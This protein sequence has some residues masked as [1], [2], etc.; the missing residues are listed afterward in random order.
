MGR[1]LIVVRAGS[2]PS[3]AQ[4]CKDTHLIKPTVAMLHAVL[5]G[6]HQSNSFCFARKASSQCQTEVCIARH[7]AGWHNGILPRLI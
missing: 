5:L 2:L 4:N 1:Y 3:T 6:M 7:D